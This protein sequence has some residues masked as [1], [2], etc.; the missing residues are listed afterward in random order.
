[1]VGLPEYASPALHSLFRT[2][3][4]ASV[5]LEVRFD[6]MHAYSNAEMEAAR[7]EAPADIK[8][9]EPDGHYGIPVLN[10]VLP[11]GSSRYV[12]A[13]YMRGKAEELRED[14]DVS[15]SKLLSAKPSRRPSVHP[16]PASRH[17]WAMRLK[18]CLQHVA[19]DWLR[20]CLPSEVEA[21]VL[22]TVK[23]GN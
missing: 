21:T 5:G 16:R 3:I 23:R 1:M 12:H 2:S 17:A 9:P 4:K 6:K 18:H 10:Y 15:M 8:W 7:R 19:G 13:Y 22:T 11:L 20:N 14:V